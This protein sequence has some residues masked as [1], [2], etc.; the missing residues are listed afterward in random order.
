MATSFLSFLPLTSYNVTCEVV[1]YIATWYSYIYCLCGT[2][3]KINV[4]ASQHENNFIF[5][6][7]LSIICS[8]KQR[9]PWRINISLR[10]SLLL[11]WNYLYVYEHHIFVLISVTMFE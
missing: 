1:S 7:M 5:K 4:I 6:V 10:I 11:V 3:T 8:L 2:Q 9:V